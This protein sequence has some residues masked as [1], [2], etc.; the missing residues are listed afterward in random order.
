MDITNKILEWILVLKRRPLMI[1]TDEDSYHSLQV[2]IE[3]YVDA[4]GHVHNKNLRLVISK[5]YQGKIN[6]SSSVHWASQIR[7]LYGDKTED[8]QKKILLKSLEDYF[9][10][11]KFWYKT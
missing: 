8:E 3:G 9:L 4:L 1:L 11:N 2:Y 7:Y 6:Q 5:W 10:E